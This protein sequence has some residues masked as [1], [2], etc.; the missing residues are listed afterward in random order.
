MAKMLRALG[1]LRKGHLVE[2]NR[3]G[4]CAGFEGQTGIKTTE[5]VE[6]ALGGA[7]EQ[8]QQ[9]QQEQQ[10]QQGSCPCPAG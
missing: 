9:Q 5:V 7:Q 4:L 2:T 8:Q 6:S 3:A 1:F 10:Q